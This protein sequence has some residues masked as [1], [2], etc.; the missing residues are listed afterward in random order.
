M[1]QKKIFGVFAFGI[2]LLLS[3]SMVFAFGQGNGMPEER[4]EMRNAI[5]LERAEFR[6]ALAE[7]R[8][9]QDFELMKELKAQFHPGKRMNHRN[10]NKTPCI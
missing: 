6:E 2:C 8:A 9:N 7:A 5:Q 3:M 10:S 1:K 4:E